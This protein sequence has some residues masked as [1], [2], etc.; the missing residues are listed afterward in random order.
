M[1]GC[2]LV[3]GRR[4][5]RC[6]SGCQRRFADGLATPG[7][8]VPLTRDV[9]LFTEAAG[10]GATLLWLHTFGIRYRN[11]TEGRGSQ[12]P[13]I[14]GLHWVRAVTALPEPWPTAPTTPTPVNSTSAAA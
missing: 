1:V 9:E 11:T 14:P 2:P 5:A 12:V 7:P 10:V 8:R 6:C 4:C 13:P 3:A